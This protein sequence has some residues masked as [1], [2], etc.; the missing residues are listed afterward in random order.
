MACHHRNPM[1]C[2]PV[3]WHATIVSKMRCSPVTLSVLQPDVTPGGNSYD[4]CH[5]IISYPISSLPVW[6]NATISNSTSTSVACHANLLYP[7]KMLTC[8]LT[9]HHIIPQ[10]DAHLWIDMPPYYTATR[11]SAVACHSTILYSNQMLTCGVPFHHIIL[12][13]NAHL[14]STIPSYY[15]PTRCSPVG[16]HATILYSNKML[17][18]GVPF[19]HIIPQQAKR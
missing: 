7:N 5:V 19:H 9:C 12:Q 4:G 14:W 2:S 1:S 18:C 17:T 6:F 13:Q 11:C 15:T 3:V 8:G 10:Q 16:C